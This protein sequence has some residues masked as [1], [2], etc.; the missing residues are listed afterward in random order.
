VILGAFGAVDGVSSSGVVTWDVNMDGTTIFTT[1][2]NRPEVAQSAFVGPLE[3][4]DIT[5]WDAGSYLTVDVDDEGTG[6]EGGMVVIR[7]REA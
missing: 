4:P 6:A 1:T 3:T 2:A 7:Y 5:A